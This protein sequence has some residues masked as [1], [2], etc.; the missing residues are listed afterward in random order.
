[1]YKLSMLLLKDI[2]THSLE[3]P[4]VNKSHDSVVYRHIID[5]LVTSVRQGCPLSSDHL[6]FS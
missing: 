2:N 6:C 5:H 4:L 1:M 3:M